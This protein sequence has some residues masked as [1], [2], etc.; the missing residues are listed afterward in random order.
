MNNTLFLNVT[1]GQVASALRI[2]SEVLTIYTWTS[3][4][5]KRA[6][7]TY[8]Q[9]VESQERVAYVMAVRVY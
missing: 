5:I 4:D 1:F 6:V 2:Y 7:R 3:G 9:S 8:K